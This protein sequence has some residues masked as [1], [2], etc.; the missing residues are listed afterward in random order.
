M[1]YNVNSCSFLRFGLRAIVQFLYLTPKQPPFPEHPSDSPMLGAILAVNLLCVFWH[2]LFAP[3]AAGE[4][5][6]GYLHGGLAMDFIGQAG[7][8]SRIHLFLLDMLVIVLQLTHMSAYMLQR[9]LKDAASGTATSSAPAVNAVQP[10]PASAQDLD[11]EERG[12]R[13]STEQQDI[14]MQ[15]LNPSGTANNSE[16][17][18]AEAATESNHERSSLLASTSAPAMP[19]PQIVDDA[20]YSGQIVVANLD[21]KERIKDQFYLMKNYRTDAQ[22]SN[23][24]VTRLRM[25]L[26]QR[27]LRMRMGAD[28]LRESI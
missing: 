20:L 18:A 17:P 22:S 6:R 1:T 23:T 10:A 24:G 15:N 4:Q 5:T 16:P 12:V 7:P 8:S 9:R 25:E 27:V 28:A 11:A 14:E 3:P 13:R 26:A 19:T 2:L 21:I